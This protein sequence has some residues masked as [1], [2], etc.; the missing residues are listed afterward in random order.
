MV[1]VAERVKALELPP[2]FTSLPTSNV[3]A[4][5][6]THWPAKLH[7]VPLSRTVPGLRI[8]TV[9]L[10]VIGTGPVLVSRPIFS[11]SLAN[12]V[13]NCAVLFGTVIIPT[14]VATPPVLRRMPFV[15]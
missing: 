11:S 12:D 9:P 6:T 8:E 14:D 13:D 15:V 2:S 1:P 3:A 7:D 5:E 10:P 4:L